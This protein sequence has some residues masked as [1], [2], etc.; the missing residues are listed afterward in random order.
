ML[1]AELENITSDVTTWRHH[2]SHVTCPWSA[3]M[4]LSAE[5]EKSELVETGEI[6]SNFKLA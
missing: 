2:S 1:V 4:V 6:A 3:E 5:D